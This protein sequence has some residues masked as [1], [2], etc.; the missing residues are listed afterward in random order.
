MGRMKEKYINNLSEEDIDE[1]LGDTPFE[2]VEYMV[3]ETN[4]MSVE[5]EIDAFKLKYSD[6]D[7]KEVINRVSDSGGYTN[8]LFK[9]FLSELHSVYLAKNG[10]D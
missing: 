1:L 10:Y 3:P 4:D 8:Q 7:I 2:F 9:M 5:E 6:N